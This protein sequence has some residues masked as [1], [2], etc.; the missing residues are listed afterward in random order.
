[1]YRVR[2]VSDFIDYY[3]HMF[4]LSGK[5]WHRNSRDQ[6][7]R[8]AMFEVMSSMGLNIPVIGTVGEFWAGSIKSSSG[9]M[10]AY[11]DEYAPDSH[12]LVWKSTFTSEYIEDSELAPGTTSWRYLR[13]GTLS[14]IWLEYQS[15]DKWRS[16]YGDVQ[17][18][19]LNNFN[20]RIG[21]CLPVVEE[22]E[23]YP[24]LAIDFV[25]SSKHKYYAID[26]NTSPGLKWTGIE[27]IYKPTEIADSVREWYRRREND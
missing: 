26:Y 9:K 23:P 3:D 6:F 22:N 14:P 16:N 27:D 4:D 17:I 5:V 24:M 25:R 12:E 1:M 21:L 2:L 11:Y 18:S 8:Q 15:T 19:I 10:V 13:I 7:S 20:Y